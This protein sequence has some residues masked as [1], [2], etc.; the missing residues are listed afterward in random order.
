MRRPIQLLRL[1]GLLACLLSAAYILVQLFYGRV[2]RTDTAS[3][4]EVILTKLGGSPWSV[5]FA[6]LGAVVLLGA[7]LWLTTREAELLRPRRGSLVLLGTQAVLAMLASSELLYLVAAEVSFLLPLR[8]GIVW[9]VLQSLAEVASYYVHTHL[10]GSKPYLDLLDVSGLPPG[11]VFALVLASSQVYHFLAFSMGVVGGVES[12]Q[13]RELARVNAELRA[14]RQ[15]EADTA[16]LAERLTLSRELHDAAGHHLAALSV[17]LRLMRRLA[18]PAA[19]EAKLDESL[20]VVQS[21]LGDVRGV[22]RDLRDVRAI[23]LKAALQTLVDGLPG[24]RVHLDVDDAL[25]TAEPFQAHT[26]FRCA[27]EVLT[28]ALRHAEARNLWLSLSRTPEGLRLSARDDGRGTRHLHLG[29]GLTGM[30]ERIAEIGGSFEV[31][32]REGKGFG[33]SLLLPTRGE[34]A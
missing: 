31:D 29:H 11:V 30:Q 5:T 3:L 34:L 26:L 2:T 16:R 22:V 20:Q 17:N 6:Q 24:L 23:N 25:A 9:I 13:R 1:A 21:L 32:S 8:A 4:L 15:L 19:V 27:Q 10:A 18:E 14:T 33:V 7:V 28:N 12:R